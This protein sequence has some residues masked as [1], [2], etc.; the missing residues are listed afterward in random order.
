MRWS[1]R[2]ARARVFDPRPIRLHLRSEGQQDKHLSLR[3]DANRDAVEMNRVS[4]A[5]CAQ[6][7][8]AGA[9]PRSSFMSGVVRHGPSP[10][11]H[12]GAQRNAGQ[13]SAEGLARSVPEPASCCDVVF[14]Y[15]CKLFLQRGKANSQIRLFVADRADGQTGRSSRTP[16]RRAGRRRTK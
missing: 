4:C 2:R 13:H 1:D 10:R 6:S 9:S 7:A 14:R 12:R 8:I 16:R 11:A 15:A 5:A 3:L